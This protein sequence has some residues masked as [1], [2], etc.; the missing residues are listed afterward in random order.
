MTA[1]GR[2]CTQGQ[3]KPSWNV[4]KKVH[5]RIITI[6]ISSKYSYGGLVPVYGARRNT[7]TP[8]TSTISWLVSWDLW[9]SS[10]CLGTE[11]NVSHAWRRCDGHWDLFCFFWGLPVFCTGQDSG[12]Y[13]GEW[14]TVLPLLSTPSSS[15]LAGLLCFGNITNNLLWAFWLRS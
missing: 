2:L 9:H 5:I 11:W 6:S 3:M 8:C 12:V 10:K 13:G 15:V 7:A 4:T 1:G 14:G